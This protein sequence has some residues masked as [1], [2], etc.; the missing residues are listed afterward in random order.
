MDYPANGSRPVKMWSPEPGVYVYDFGQNF[1]GW[2]RIWAKGPAGTEIKLRYAELINTDGTLN[3]KP[4]RGARATDIY[5]TKGE[6]LEVYEPRFT[7]HGFRYLE[8]TGYPGVP[9]LESVEG[10]VIHSSVERTGSFICSNQLIS[11][12]FP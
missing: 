9:N 5:I 3:V 4:N 7:Y 1:S 2:A 8:V 10:R 11:W 12:V 6:G